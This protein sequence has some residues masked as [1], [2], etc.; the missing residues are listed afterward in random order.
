VPD[1][2]AAAGQDDERAL[3]LQLDVDAP[4][5]GVYELAAA[6]HRG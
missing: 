6:V 4:G 5:L 2:R 3:A 1:T